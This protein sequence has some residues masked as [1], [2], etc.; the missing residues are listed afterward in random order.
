M[1]KPPEEKIVERCS[2]AIEE[3]VCPGGVIGV[4]R[5]SGERKLFSFG[6]QTYDLTSPFVVDDTIYDVASITKSIPTAMLALAL[7]D[8]GAL[9]LDEPVASYIPEVKNN[10]GDTVLVK[11]LLTYTI[12]SVPL[13]EMK[14]SSAE[15]ILAYVFSRPLEH[16][17]GSV[18]RYSNTPALLLGLIVERVFGVSLA[19]AANDNFFKPL[20]MKRTGFMPQQKLRQ[21][22]APSEGGL[23]GEV[24][25]ESARVFSKEGR[26]VGHAGLFSTAPD[27]LNFLEMLLNGGEIRGRRYFSNQIIRDVATNQIAALGDSTG[28]GWELNQPRFMGR[29]RSPHTFGKTG[30]TGTSIVCDIERDIAFVM[31]TNRTFPKRPPDDTAINTFR[32]DIADIFLS[33]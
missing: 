27:L 30:F 26:S 5:T 20:R 15:E 25:D 2:R 33:V 23:R 28:L 3:N 12:D 11:H 29:H 21:D 18:F 22:I 10:Y 14:D 8:K 9:G 17:P 1:K 4:V 6:H 16:E 32:N 7:I 19:Q 13:S 24:H 31:L